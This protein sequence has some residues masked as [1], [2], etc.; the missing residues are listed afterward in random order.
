MLKLSGLSDGKLRGVA[1]SIAVLDPNEIWASRHIR[2]GED[3]RLPDPAAA[4][5]GCYAR[6]ANREAI[7]QGEV[8]RVFGQHRGERSGNNL[9]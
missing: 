2:N 9:Y 7:L 1:P 3:E 8:L 6:D 5:Q 4:T